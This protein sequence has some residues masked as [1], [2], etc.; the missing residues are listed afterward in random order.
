MK[1]LKKRPFGLAFAFVW[2]FI[3]SNTIEPLVQLTDEG[4]QLMSHTTILILL[5]DLI[6]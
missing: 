3:E 6:G 2:F 4:K 5:A 1:S